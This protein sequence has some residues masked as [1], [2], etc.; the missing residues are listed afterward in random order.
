MSTAI[1][2]RQRLET[3][4]EF[5]NNRRDSLMAIAAEGVDVRKVTRIA[6]FEAAKNEKIAECTPNSMYLALAKACELNLVA[7][8]VLHRCALVPRWSKAK[9]A[10]EASL[11][12]EYTGLMELVRRSGEIANFVARVVHEN[13]HFEHNFDL[14]SGETLKHTPCYD[15]NP[16][17]MR[18]AYAVCHFKDGQK[19]VEVMRRDQIE[20]IR[21][22]SKYSDSGPWAD[23]TEE[24][25]RKT[26]IRRICKYLPLTPEAQK[27]FAHDINDEFGNTPLVADSII[28]AIAVDGPLEIEDKGLEPEPKESKAKGVVAKAKTNET[29][30]ALLQEQPT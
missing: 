13:E 4:A 25:W 8:G 11:I 29:Q 16:G 14:E 20:R 5:L 12:V 1:T 3:L 23:H 26:V 21:R 18:L 9:R 30:Q 17:E 22:A 6:L 2:K 7:G 28:N 19:Q 15:G 27:V 24:M 10:M